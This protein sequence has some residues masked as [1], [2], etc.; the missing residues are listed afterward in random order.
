VNSKTWSCL[1]E[2]MRDNL[3]QF[4]KENLNVTVSVGSQDEPGRPTVTVRLYIGDELISEDSSE[5]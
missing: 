5:K 4:L 2:E 3:T 1:S